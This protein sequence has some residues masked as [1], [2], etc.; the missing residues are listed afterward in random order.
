MKEPHRTPPKFV[1]GAILSILT[2]TIE[3]IMGRRL[4]DKVVYR[5]RIRIKA[6]KAVPVIAEAVKVAKNTI[7]K[8]RFGASSGTIIPHKRD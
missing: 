5:I 3:V 8:M 7:Y 6:G 1:W 4:L 2:T